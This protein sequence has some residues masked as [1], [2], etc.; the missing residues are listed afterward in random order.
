MNEFAICEYEEKYKDDLIAMILGI[1]QKEFGIAITREDQPD[2][3]EI[4]QYYQQGNGNFWV[5]LYEE[6]VV[7]T[8]GLIDIGNQQGALRKMFVKLDYRGAEYGVAQALL[9]ELIRWSA[10][11]GVQTVYLGTTDKFKAAH[12]F[13]EKNGFTRIEKAGLPPGFPVMKVD[14]VFYRAAATR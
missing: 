12:R 6:G 9:Q 5:A 11:H 8:I 7:G 10:G 13:Y 2:L 1:Q 14:T 4:S 3:E